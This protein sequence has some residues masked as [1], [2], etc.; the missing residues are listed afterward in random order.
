M[1]INNIQGVAQLYG[2]NQKKAPAANQVGI[3]EAAASDE[4]VLSETAQSFAQVLQKA[5]KNMGEVRQDR[6]DELTR[7]IAAG[8]YQVNAQAIADKLMKVSY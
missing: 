4:V 5:Q 7:R 3:K 1:M 6:V 8:T 2:V